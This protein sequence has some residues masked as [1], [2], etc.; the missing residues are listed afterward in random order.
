M[1]PDDDATQDSADVAEVRVAHSKNSLN[2]SLATKKEDEDER[3]PLMRTKPIGAGC[4]PHTQAEKDRQYVFVHQSLFKYREIPESLRQ[5]I[6]EYFFLVDTG[7]CA[8]HSG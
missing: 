3:A 8:C 7:H 5:V 2:S 1:R 6:S 4:K